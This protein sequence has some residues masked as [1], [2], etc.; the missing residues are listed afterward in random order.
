MQA[1]VYRG[2]DDVQ[3]ETLAVPELRPGEALVRVHSCGICGTDLKKIHHGLTP[4]PRVFGHEMAGTIAEVAEGVEGWAVGDRV[5]VMHHV[6]CMAC[7]YCRHNAFAQC[8]TY[9]RTGTTAG[10]EPAGGGY[11]Q[12]IRVMDWVV[13]KGMVRIPDGVSFEEATFVEPVN[14]VLKGV[15]KADAGSETT[16]LVIG[17]GQI[18]LLFNQVL[19][20]RGATVYGSDPLAFRREQAVKFGAT[21][22]F[23]PADADLAAEMR[24]RTEGRGVDLAVV[25]VPDGQ[26]AAQA[27]EAVRPGGKVLLFAHTR[28][29][30]PLTVDGGA[31]CMLEKDLIGS[32]SS[33]ITI[34]DQA[35]SLVFDRTID[36][37]SLITHCFPLD[38]ITEAIRLASNPQDNSLKVM[39]S[40]Q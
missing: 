14:T 17:Q 22:A 25:A 15:L 18:G 28:L 12:Y 27:F 2:V 33:D 4:P 26:V 38:E 13:R 39:V 10:F 23:S 31:V 24:A 35:A 6:P 16:A 19:R 3:V 40:L 30:D 5:A 32:Y 36:V 37:K 7:H 8:P 20:S 21:E 9:T 29:D 34:Q 1:A 11:A